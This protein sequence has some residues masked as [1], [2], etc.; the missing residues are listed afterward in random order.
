[1][2][3][4]A[5]FR[6]EVFRPLV[7]LVIPGTVAIAPYVL[8]LRARYGAVRQFWNDH[9][10]TSVAVLGLAAVTIGLILEGVGAQIESRWDRRL[11]AN[12]KSHDENWWRYLRLTLP[13]EPIGQRYL[14]TVTLAMK[15]EFA[16]AVALIVALAGTIWLNEAAPFVSRGGMFGT[17]VGVLLLTGYLLYESWCSAKVLGRVRKELVEEFYRPA[18]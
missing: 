14:R 7:T 1:M 11:T 15:F 10:S 18:V 5:P 3:L 2:D 6:S 13:L 9:T 12:D 17:G 4:G 8:L 16:M